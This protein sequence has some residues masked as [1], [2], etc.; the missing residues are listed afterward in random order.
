MNAN[1]EMLVCSFHSYH[2]VLLD[3]IC[4]VLFFGFLLVHAE[5]VTDGFFTSTV[6]K[7]FFFF[8]SG[9][10]GTCIVHSLVC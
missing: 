7:H 4:L 10:N 6:S 8:K 1:E 9:L 2:L 3:F 5:I